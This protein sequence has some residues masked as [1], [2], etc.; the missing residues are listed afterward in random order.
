VLEPLLNINLVAGTFPK[1]ADRTDSGGKF[2]TFL[3]YDDCKNFNPP[4][5]PCINAE[6][7]ITASTDNGKTWSAPVSV[8]NASGHHFYPAITT[9]AST[10][11]VTFTYYST[12][13]DFFNHGVQVWGNQIF[14]GTATVGTPQRVTKVLDPIDDNPKDLGLLQSD[15]FMGVIARGNGLSGQSRVYTSFDSTTVPGNYEGR[16]DADLNNHISVFSY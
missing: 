12:Q 2:T 15:A 1:H 7:L 4:N 3:M 10:G 8:D 6:V 11:I 14:P 13:G 5:G 16:P 9:D